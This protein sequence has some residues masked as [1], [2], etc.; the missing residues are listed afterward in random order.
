MIS[1]ELAL[2]FADNK[3]FVQ[4]YRSFISMKEIASFL[5]IFLYI[6]RSQSTFCRQKKDAI[7]NIR[8]MMKEHI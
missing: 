5:C 8:S 6:N 7:C 2:A 1:Y 4:L 3:K